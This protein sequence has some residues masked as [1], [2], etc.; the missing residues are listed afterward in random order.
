MHIEE[1]VLAVS[2][3]GLA[4]LAGSAVL[5]AAGTAFGLRRINYERVPQV[6]VLSAAFFVASLVHVPMGFT[7][8]HLVLNGLVGLL[9]GWAAFPAIL[10]ALFLQSVFF[11]FGGLL[12]LG[13]NTVT[14]A[15]PA[16]AVGYL[17]GG[18]TRAKS[19][20]A[21]FV[22]GFAAG[23]MGI[24]LGV[25]FLAA[26]M[27]AAQREFRTLSQAVALAYLGVAVIEGLVT[28]SAVAF[29]RKVRPELLEAPLA[30]AR[31]ETSDA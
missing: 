23:A 13:V 28:A 15:V 30:P 25:V 10:V 6:G 22:A 21:A 3:T 31:L 2:P 19:E 12:T 14:M 11:G 20:A 8:V 17:F 5:A 26:A 9:L 16:V 27:I 24:L 4:I 1:G 29:L 7:S 18:A